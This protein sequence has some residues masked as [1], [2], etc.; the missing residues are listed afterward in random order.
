MSAKWNAY[1]K[2]FIPQ[3]ISGSWVIWVLQLGVCFSFLGNKKR[4]QHKEQNKVVLEDTVNK[5]FVGKY[6]EKQHEWGKVVF[7]RG[8]D[9]TMAHS[10]CGIIATY[11]ARAFLEQ[12]D[13][14]RVHNL[15]ELIGYFE[16]NG[17]VL[18]GRFGVSPKAIMKC[19]KRLDY[20]VEFIRGK[21]CATYSDL[22]TIGE[23]YQAVVVTFFNHEKDITRMMHTVCVTKE[24]GRYF[25]H[26]A[27]SFACNAPDGT[28]TLAEAVN[29][30]A[31]LPKVISVIG[32]SKKE[33]NHINS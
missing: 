21:R 25:A 31:T 23:K 29:A 18:G 9:N 7:G 12:W 22:N 16:S 27:V 19:F 11:N 2:A 30:S 3:K 14:P 10:G 33:N 28:Q 24:N 8:K 13:V 1:W 32:V 5:L 26:N 20:N 6:I 4:Q 17:A 15:V